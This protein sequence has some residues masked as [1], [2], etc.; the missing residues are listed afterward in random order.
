MKKIF[1]II[2]LGIFFLSIS[3]SVYGACISVDGRDCPDCPTAGG[4]VPCGRSCDNLDTTNICECDLCQ[5]CHLFVLFQNII[6]FLMVPSATNPMPI[7]LIIAVLMITIGGC[8][9]M[10]GGGNP[11]MLKQGKEILKATGIGL[12]IIY[13]AW[14]FV[15]LI[16]WGIGVNVWTGPGEGWWKINCP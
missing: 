2:F 4:L 15:D 9:Y 10:F 8:M 14:I 6:N 16:F 13:G 12:L 7:V 5:L 3:N 1:L 11:N